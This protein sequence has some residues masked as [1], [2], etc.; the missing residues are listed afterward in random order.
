M[1]TA[2]CPAVWPSVDFPH[3]ISRRSRGRQ[4]VAGPWAGTGAYVAIVEEQTLLE[5]AA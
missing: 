4:A 3:G 2:D 5:V 1:H